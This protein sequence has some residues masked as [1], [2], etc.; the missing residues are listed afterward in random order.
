MARKM[1][2]STIQTW[3]E[4]KDLRSEFTQ[5]HADTLRVL[6]MEN[7]EPDDL[8]ILFE[9]E[10]MGLLAIPGPAERPDLDLFFTDPSVRVTEL[11][12]FMSVPGRTL[13]MTERN[14]VTS[15]LEGATRT[16]K[17]L[18]GTADRWW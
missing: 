9:M 13:T 15:F 14:F 8:D 17:F 4:Y 5:R 3:E 7:E 11:G 2:P 16:Q 6:I 12:Y 10:E 1:P 18:A